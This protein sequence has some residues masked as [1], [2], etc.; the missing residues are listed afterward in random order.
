MANCCITN[1]PNGTG[2]IVECGDLKWSHSG[3]KSGACSQNGGVIA[4][5][6]RH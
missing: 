2:Y 3:G 4:T 1:F 6:Y 5:L